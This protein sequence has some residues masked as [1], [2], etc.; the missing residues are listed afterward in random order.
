MCHSKKKIN[1]SLQYYITNE[2]ADTE[3]ENANNVHPPFP[4][5][6]AMTSA[7]GQGVFLKNR[8]VSLLKL[9]KIQIKKALIIP[10]RAILLWSWWAC[11]ITNT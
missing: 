5:M 11:K 3:Y 1:S 8:S 10:Q 9:H 4:T 6:G 2:Y 7:S